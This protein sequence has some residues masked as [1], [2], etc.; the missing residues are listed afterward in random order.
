VVARH[1]RSASH[2]KISE[3]F[4]R[5]AE[6][7]AEAVGEEITKDRY[8]E[9]LKIAFTVW[10]AVVFDTHAGNG[11]FVSQLR[12]WMSGNP[13]AAAMVEQLIQRKKL[14]FAD[15]QRVIGRYELVQKNGEWRLWAEA[16]DPTPRS[17][18]EAKLRE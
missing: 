2:P 10:N 3:T 14:H 5:F 8:E 7:L 12:Q 16:R 9:I 17:G 13:L 18:M 1:R 4:Q 6:P 15:D 11:N